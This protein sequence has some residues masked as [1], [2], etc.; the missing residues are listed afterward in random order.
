M[1]I[2]QALT[3][4]FSLIMLTAAGGFVLMASLCIQVFIAL[5]STLPLIHRAVEKYPNF[6]STKAKRRV[7]QVVVLVVILSAVCVGLV[8]HFLST[9]ALYGFFGGMILALVASLKRI[10]P[11][12]QVNQ[13]RFQESYA[14]CFPPSDMNPDD[15]AQ[16][17]VVTPPSDSSQD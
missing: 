2:T 16:N 9:F 1:S 5:F 10:S 3:S 14:D 17:P 6:N 15:V 7:F 8:F 4:P 12:S 11:N 13:D